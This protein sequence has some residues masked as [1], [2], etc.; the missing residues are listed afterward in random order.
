[1]HNTI[2]IGVLIGGM[3]IER[4]VSLNSGRTIC[5][6]LDTSLYTVIPLFHHTDGYIYRLPWRFLHRGKVVDF[7]YRLAD[8]AP[9]LRWDELPDQI[10]FLYSAAHGAHG[11]DG[12][13]QGMCELL[14]I[15]YLGSGI[16]ASTR[17]I[18]KWHQRE[19][20]HDLNVAHPHTARVTPDD[21]P[22]DE[23]DMHRLIEHLHT[24]G[25]VFPLIV[26]PRYEG[27]SLGVSK[28][29]TSSELHGAL[30]HAMYINTHAQDALIQECIEGTEICQILLAHDAPDNLIALP[31]TEI[32]HEHGTAIFDYSQKYMPG[33]A[34]KHTPPRC[35]EAVITQMQQTAQHIAT[36]YQ[37]RT[38]VRIDYM[39]THNGTAYV[40]DINTF[41][42]TAPSA[43][44]FL[45]AAEI[46]L[47]H[48]DVINR[49]IQVEL[50]E[51]GLQQQSHEQG[52]YMET[53]HRTQVAVI[54]GGS[55]H[56][57]EVSLESGRNACYKL[58]PHTYDVT[59]L[60]MSSEHKLYR[61]TQRH[62]VRN[63]TEEIENLVSS[64]E[65]ILWHD[66][67]R[68][69]DFVFLGLHGGVGEN[70][71]VQGALDMR[72]MPYNGS[73][74][75]ASALCMNKYNVH[76][77][78]RRHGFHVPPHEYIT[79]EQ[80]QSGVHETSL[81]YPII[82]K[83]NDDGSSVNV[84]KANNH[85]ECYQALNT[86]FCDNTVFCDNNSGALIEE[87]ISGME[88]TVGVIGNE[89][90]YAFPPSY[91]VS[92]S[93]VLSME[94]KF[95]PG[96]GEN[97]TPAPLTEDELTFIRR[98]VE[99]AYQAL[100]CQ[101]YARIDCF[102]QNAQQSLTGEAR[103]VFLEPNTLPALTPATCIF[104][105]AAEVGLKP[106]EF[107][108]MLVQLGQARYAQDTSSSTAVTD[109][110]AQQDAI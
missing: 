48:T 88:L 52:S 17:A 20:L 64:D 9:A 54:L 1:M 87:M 96:A 18:D 65:Q 49:C 91:A 13:L 76:Q 38:C 109:T 90:A 97:Q 75:H 99:Q 58:S 104:H 63:T 72:N 23:Q 45:Q 37:F 34:H 12:T 83:P 11:E 69:F 19:L 85:D 105:Q 50:Q 79:R 8:E 2:R 53:Q 33:R 27:S 73:G 92:Q 51:K 101:G 41:P 47:S 25:F 35:R 39:L 36:A 103:V 32:A 108:D 7:A 43:F 84:L 93:D 30:H 14:G 16:M 62:L 57:R 80:W 106:M 55:C 82:V 60:F 26:K 31:P 29:T 71:A 77:C 24:Q 98:E 61:I 5:D 6:H 56:E 28:V 102:Y 86:I 21:I 68:L 110:I 44:A 107:F 81:K 100:G 94:E 22:R 15:P 70:G 78:L 59:P 67:P 46:G 95:L 66:L 10:D 4:D 74:R 42:G 3:S 40:I 89:T